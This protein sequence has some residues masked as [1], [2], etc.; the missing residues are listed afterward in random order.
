MVFSTSGQGIGNIYKLTGSTAKNFAIDSLYEESGATGDE[1]IIHVG[2]DALWG[3]NGRIESLIGVDAFGDV[4]ADDVSRWI[5]SKVAS[6]KGWNA[7]YN[8][9]TQKAYF[10]PDDGNEGWAFNKFLYDPSRLI[11]R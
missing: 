3:R 1:A 4:E 5:A 6:V 7:K 8:R 11:A 10:W 2:N 9:R